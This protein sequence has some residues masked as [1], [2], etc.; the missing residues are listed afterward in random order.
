MHVFINEYSF[1]G[2]ATPHNAPAIM[3]QLS[4]TLDTL[5][6]CQC[7]GRT[8]LHSTLAHQPLIGEQTLFDWL[9][10]Q[11]SPRLQQIKLFLIVTLRKGPFID[12]VMNEINHVCDHQGTDVSSSA[13][14]GAAH[15]GGVL[16]SLAHCEMFANED[17]TVE[18]Y[19]ASD[20][21]PKD[22]PIK[23]Y[24]E[25]RQ[26]RR[27]RRLYVPNPKHRPMKAREQESEVPFE[28][29]KGQASQM[30]L[31]FAYLSIDD[32]QWEQITRFEVDPPLTE[33]QRL[34][35]CAEQGGKQ[36][37]ALRQEAGRDVFYEFQPDNAG[38]YHGYPVPEGQVPANVARTLRQRSQ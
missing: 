5:R 22:V 14:A 25:P 4:E 15:L 3:Q 10:N 28:F 34:L 1:V 13:L 17:I 29:I 20:E 24:C 23:N 36:Y 27:I 6:H 7:G 2:Q 9:F 18:L 19:R 30:P 38:G 8:M 21:Q 26:A 16:V 37:Y 11:R 32:A 31:D 12:T 35:D 33:V